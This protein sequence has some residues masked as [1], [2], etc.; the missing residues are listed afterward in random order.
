M[1]YLEFVIRI[2]TFAVTLFLLLEFI[3]G[4]QVDTWK[5][6]GIFLFITLCVF[7]A[8]F[9]TNQHNMRRCNRCNQKVGIN[10]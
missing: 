3:V 8:F 2:I 4:C 1:K 9:L 7:A 10:T 6:G 5:A